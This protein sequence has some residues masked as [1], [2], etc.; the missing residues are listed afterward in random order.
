MSRVNELANVV[1]AFVAVITALGGLL[2][3][4]K[5]VI[6]L[7]RKT[8]EIHVMV[9]S[10]RQEAARF[11]ALLVAKLTEAGIAVPLDKALSAGGDAA[12]LPPESLSTPHVV[13]RDGRCVALGHYHP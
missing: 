4:L 8:Q 1:T 10:Q 2:V 11:Q 5:A 13:G 7:L 3:A 12:H 9:N 6:P